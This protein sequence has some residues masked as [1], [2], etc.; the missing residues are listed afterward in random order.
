V[1]SLTETTMGLSE[2]IQIAQKGDETALNGVCQAIWPVVDAYVRKQM[3]G[4]DEDIT[5]EVIQETMISFAQAIPTFQGN[6]LL[7]TYS[8]AV[9]DPMKRGL[10]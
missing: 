2:W 8:V 6:C 5:E 3:R 10:K 9:F 4:I 1:N 7:S